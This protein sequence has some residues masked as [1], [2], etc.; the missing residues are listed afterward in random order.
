MMNQSTAR[1]LRTMRACATAAL[2]CAAALPAAQAACQYKQLGAIPA[3]W[4]DRRLV[5]EGRVNNAPLKMAVDT[6]T[7]W[8]TLS[9]VVAARLN[10][11][12]GVHAVVWSGVDGERSGVSAKLDQLSIGR[13]QWHDTNVVVSWQ[14]AGAP[15]VQVGANLLLEHD[16]EL[17]GRRI[18]FYEP[19]GCDD[20][21]LGYWADDVPWVPTGTVTP[22]DQ[23]TTITVQVNGQPMRALVDS[24]STATILDSAVASRLGVGT[25]PSGKAGGSG[26]HA[27]A[28]LDS[29]AIGP[30]I[31]KHAR[32]QLGDIRE[33]GAQR[34]IA[35]PVDVILGADFLQSHR[36][37]FA[38]SQRRMYFTYL[39]GEVF[40]AP[41][42]EPVASR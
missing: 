34:P 7:T 23:R 32:I 35:E 21:A 27:V 29:I 11:P 1:A 20:A 17:D 4:V 14:P 28:V 18:V 24:G 13:F 2:A 12:Q 16:V 10:V 5:I 33:T 38:A 30:E 19:A 9:S 25:A 6:G 40:H 41:E 37:L 31:I 3:T 22:R 36:L 42:A 39:G 8:T 26:G 15:D